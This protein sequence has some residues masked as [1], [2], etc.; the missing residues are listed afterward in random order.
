MTSLLS[1][2]FQ[3]IG[4]P[5][6]GKTA[7]LEG[8]ASRMVA[9]EVPETIQHKRML[10]IDLASIMAGT[11]IRGQSEQKFK[12]EP[13]P[14][15]HFRKWQPNSPEFEIDPQLATAGDII[16]FMDEVHTLFQLG[17]AEG[18]INA[19]QMIKPAALYILRGLESRYQVHHGGDFR[20]GHRHS[21]GVDLSAIYGARYI[22]DRYLPDKAIDLV[23]GATST[24]R[25]AQES[26]PDELEVLDREIITLQIELESL[27]IEMDVLSVERRSAVEGLLKEKR[28]TASELTAIWQAERARLGR[29]KD[30]KKRL[31]QAKHELDMAQ[32]QGQYEAASRLRFGVIPELEQQLPKEED[33]AAKEEEDF[34]LA[35]LHDRMTSNDIAQVVAKTMGIHVQN[36]LK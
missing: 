2:H 17:K 6:V 28:Q 33:C 7:I 15:V 31:E 11:G 27:K 8:I 29:I 16:C 10:S 9:K 19:G 14:Q 4:P 5:G 1:F 22:S 32:R 12:A 13:G 25:I 26:K 36:L 30:A 21:Y 20:C 18:N 24:I 35:M 3:L 34:S 23:D